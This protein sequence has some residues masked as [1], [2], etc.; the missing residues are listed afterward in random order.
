MIKELL[1]QVKEE[2]PEA[3]L[4]DGFD[5]AIIGVC[6]RFGQQA[7]VAYDYNKIIE[8]LT[9]D[10]IMNEQEAIEYFEFNIIGAW[11]GDGTP[12]FVEMPA[13]PNG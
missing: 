13:K 7:T 10:G 4:L 1:E 5:E 11:V 6:R 12:V 8:I 3:M 2:N 9:E